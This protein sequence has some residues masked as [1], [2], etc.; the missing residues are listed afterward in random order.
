MPQID[1]QQVRDLTGEMPGSSGFLRRH[2][3]GVTD[4][5]RQTLLLSHAFQF[6][7][8]VTASPI[9]HHHTGEIGWNQF[10][11]F[12]IAMSRPHLIYRERR[13]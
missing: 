13:N 1:P 10:P 6:H 11:H 12:F 9:A 7:G 4:Q 2:F 8:I 5:M 3:G